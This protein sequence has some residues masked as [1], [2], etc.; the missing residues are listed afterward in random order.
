MTYAMYICIEAYKDH[1]TNALNRAGVLQWNISV[2]GTPQNPQA[3]LWWLF[4]ASAM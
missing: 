4:Y 2:F 3:T 1:E